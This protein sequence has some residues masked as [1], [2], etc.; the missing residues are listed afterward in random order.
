LRVSSVRTAPVEP[1][2]RTDLFDVSATPDASP[3]VTGWLVAYLEQHGGVAG[4][5]HHLTAGSGHLSLAAHH[6][7]PDSVLEVTR[8]IPPGKGMAGLAWT[9][10]VPVQTCDLQ[11]D[12]TG[13]V[14]PGARAVGAGAAAA[15]PV[16]DGTTL[17][18]VVGIAFAAPGDLPPERLHALSRG[19][20]GVPRAR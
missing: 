13:D 6:H 4:T 16:F 11:A 1:V 8:M 17:V 14:R 20:A 12:T 3:D 15:I 7:I 10:G 18:A 9:R 19:A 5:V 2:R